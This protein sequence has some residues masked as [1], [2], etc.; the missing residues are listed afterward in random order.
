MGAGGEATTTHRWLPEEEVDG[1]HGYD[2]RR[3]KLKP[4][5]KPLSKRT[6]SLERIA[7]LADWKNVGLHKKYA[8]E[9]MVGWSGRD[10]LAW[11]WREGKD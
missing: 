2:L 3:R 10:T 9:T 5:G 7:E 8:D 6:S 1:G 4:T 11:R